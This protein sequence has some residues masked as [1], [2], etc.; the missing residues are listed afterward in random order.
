MSNELLINCILD[1]N[2]PIESDNNEILCIITLMK[3]FL[4]QF[5]LDIEENVCLF[6]FENLSQDFLNELFDKNVYGD[7]FSDG[8][9]YPRIIGLLCF[10]NRFYN[11]KG[12][13]QLIFV[14]L[15]DKF[16]RVFSKWITDHGTWLEYYYKEE[17]K[18]VLSLVCEFFRKHLNSIV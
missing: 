16:E 13:R 1:L 8:I 3:E 18:G 11:L 14:Y 6:K 15:E 4:N 17:P 5:Q 7:L 2:S 10:C 12:Y 9:T